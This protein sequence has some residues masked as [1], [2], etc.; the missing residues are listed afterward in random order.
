MASLPKSS[1]PSAYV[2]ISI[3]EGGQLDVPKNLI[4]KDG[5]EGKNVVPS[6]AFLIEHKGLGKKV[7]F[8]L[9]LC[10]VHPNSPCPC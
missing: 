6:Y 3:I 5:S 10:K 2:D 7:F 1:S 4:E 9:G 8:D